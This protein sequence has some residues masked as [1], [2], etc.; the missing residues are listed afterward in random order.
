LHQKNQ[1]SAVGRA[2]TGYVCWK[3]ELATTAWDFGVLSA[4][5][6]LAQILFAFA[7]VAVLSSAGFGFRYHWVPKLRVEPEL[8]ELGHLAIGVDS[9]SHVKLHNDGRT[10][11]VIL[12][13]SATCGCSRVELTDRVVAPGETAILRVSVFGSAGQ[14]P[15]VISEV[16][17][18]TNDPRRPEFSVPV[19]CRGTYGIRCEP[20]RVDFAEVSPEELPQERRVRIISSTPSLASAKSFRCRIDDPQF[21]ARVQPTDVSHHF[22]LFVALFPGS[23]GGDLWSHAIIEGADD[24]IRCVI[25]IHATVRGPFTTTPRVVML[26]SS[27]VGDRSEGKRVSVRRRTGGSGDVTI[28]EVLIPENLRAIIDVQQRGDRL[29]ILRI[30]NEDP[31]HFRTRFQQPVRLKI[32]AAD[33]VTGEVTIP[34]VVVLRPED[35]PNSE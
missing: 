27:H 10:P 23:A 8:I 17:L 9:V 25:P 34:V 33:G 20:E 22:D 14:S 2:T 11:L 26:D 32:R 15:G 4:M 5:R 16:L 21:T 29:M 6:K 7:F 19:T 31:V 24:R 35:Q 1:M 30:A 3:R 28:T 13:Y 18:K 12:N